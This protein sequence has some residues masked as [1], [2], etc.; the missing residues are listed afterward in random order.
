MFISFDIK[1]VPS[2]K[3][4][5]IGFYI[6]IHVCIYIFYIKYFFLYTNTV[7]ETLRLCLANM[8]LPNLHLI[9]QFWKERL[10]VLWWEVLK[11]PAFS[12]RLLPCSFHAFGPLQRPSN[13]YVHTGK[14][15]L[16]KNFCVFVFLSVSF[17][18]FWCI[19]FF[20]SLNDDFG[21]GCI[22]GQANPR[23]NSCHIFC[24]FSNMFCHMSKNCHI[25]CM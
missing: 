18:C 25:I 11:H 20:I 3:N 6:C 12:P 8:Y 24:C 7:T 22:Y 1:F 21:F 16:F 17:N 23:C 13:V 2:V 10:Q 15:C 14:I 4:I 9:N 5:V 19:I